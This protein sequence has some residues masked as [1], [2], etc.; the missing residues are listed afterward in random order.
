[1]VGIAFNLMTFTGVISLQPYWIRALLYLGMGWLA[2]AL[3]L[4]MLRAVGFRGLQWAIYGGI[5]YTLGVMVD[6]QNEPVFWPGVFGSHE[7]FHV[8]A[9]VGTLCHFIFIW[10]YV[11][12]FGIA[13]EASIAT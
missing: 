8:C 2:L 3:V 6:V 11:I 7:L 9:V 10:R 5:A 1:A 13:P 4:D 12:P